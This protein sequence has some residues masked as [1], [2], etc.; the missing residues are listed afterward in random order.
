[1]STSN[2]TTQTTSQSAQQTRTQPLP[3]WLT[4]AGAMLSIGGVFGLI[5]GIA[6]VGDSKIYLG[7][8]TFM[9]GDLNTWGWTFIVLGAIQVLIALGVFTASRL[10]IAAGVFWAGLSIIA[11]LIAAAHF[12]LWSLVLIGI[13]STVIFGLIKGSSVLES[14]Q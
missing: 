4:Y 11:E 13:Q 1:M 9:F 6:M 8:Q 10:A 14:R 12:P 5:D 7:G 2:P 3:G